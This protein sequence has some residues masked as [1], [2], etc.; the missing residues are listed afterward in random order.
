MKRRGCEDRQTLEGCHQKSRTVEATGSRKQ[1]SIMTSAVLSSR[2]LLFGY[3]IVNYH[4]SEGQLSC[5]QV[6]IA[7]FVCVRIK[8]L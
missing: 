7:S 5:F 3:T 1:Q 4:P 2:T 6:G 8:T